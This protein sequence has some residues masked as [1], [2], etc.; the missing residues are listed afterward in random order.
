MELLSSSPAMMIPVSL[1]SHDLYNPLQIIYRRHSHWRLS[2]SGCEVQLIRFS[3]RRMRFCLIHMHWSSCH[4]LQQICHGSQF[5]LHHLGAVVREDSPTTTLAWLRICDVF[6]PGCVY[7]LP[8][9]TFIRDECF[10]VAENDGENKR[11]RF[12]RFDIFI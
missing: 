11:F 9:T 10:Q 7:L 8:T 12:N 4:P 6:R 5:H 2:Y 3:P 1:R